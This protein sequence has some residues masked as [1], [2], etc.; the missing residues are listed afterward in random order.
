MMLHMQQR[1]DKYSVE[2]WQALRTLIEFRS[3]R[4]NLVEHWN[5][6]AGRVR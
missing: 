1:W 6:S 2:E 3:G 5:I 4:D